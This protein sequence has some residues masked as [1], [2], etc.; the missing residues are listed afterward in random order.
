[1]RAAAPPRP[2]PAGA[3]ALSR[4][5]SRARRRTLLDAIAAD[6]PTL[7]LRLLDGSSVPAHRELLQFVSSCV[8]GLPPG[9]RARA[10]CG[11]PS[12]HD[13]TGRLHYN[14]HPIKVNQGAHG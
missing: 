4:S 9:G 10:M 13:C 6:E 11:H 14:Q 1:M 3:A 12:G 7:F 2:R 8:K 5:A